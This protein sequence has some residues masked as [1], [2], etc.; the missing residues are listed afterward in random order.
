MGTNHPV[1]KPSVF[2]MKKV[3]YLNSC[4]TCKRILKNLALSADFIM[5][6]IKTTPLTAQD[7]AHLKKLSGS[8]S[9]LFSRRAKLFQERQ[10][11]NETLDEDRY[12]ALL[13]EHYTFLKR[14]VV[15]VGQDIFIGSAKSTVDNLQHRLET[16]N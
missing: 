5:Q 14:P 7:L 13:L 3:Y 16:E 15:V 12:K 6:D 8:Y 10:L 4:S 11:Q 9:A 2:S 1:F